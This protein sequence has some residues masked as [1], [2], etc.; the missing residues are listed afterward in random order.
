MTELS[1]RQELLHALKDHGAREIFGIPGDFVLNLY[2]SLEDDGR[3]R[4]ELD[5]LT[6][7]ADQ[8][9]VATGPFQ[10]PY[11]PNHAER[12]ARDVFQTHAV[13]YR[14]ADEVPS[15]TVLVVGQEPRPVLGQA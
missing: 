15:G 14:R 4:L 9:V 5:E 3:F 8:V 12:F 13:G 1:A 10:N 7:T 6:I 2:E 11:V